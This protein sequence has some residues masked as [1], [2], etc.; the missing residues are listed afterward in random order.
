[1]SEREVY[2]VAPIVLVAVEVRHSLCEP[3]DS[4]GMGRFSAALAGIL[5]LRGEVQNVSVAFQPGVSAA[6]LQQVSAFPRWS[7]RDKRTAVTV[8]TDSLVIESTN[9]QQYEHLRDL[10]E[11]ALTARMSSAG[12]AGI[13]RVG[14]RYIDEIRVP[15]DDGDSGITWGNWVHPSL[16]GPALELEQAA[17]MRLSEHQGL[18]VFAG[19]GDHAL[20]LRYGPRE[21]YA[22]AS[23]P[24]LRRPTPPP[25]PFFL[26]DIDSFWQPSDVAPV[27]ATDIVLQ[28]MDRLHTPVRQ[29][30]EGLITDKLREEVLRGK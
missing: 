11:L 4:S 20:A 29:L 7:S 19:A 6:P 16:L 25:G 18:A 13:E 3:L 28:A 9:Y 1:M 15:T 23:S 2:P 22:T 24:E 12:T 30:F 27:M 5:P 21:G 17:G 26:L 10:L 8:R 14:M